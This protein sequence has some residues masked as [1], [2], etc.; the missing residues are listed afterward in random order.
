VE[1]GDRIPFV[2]TWFASHADPPRKINPEHALRDTEVF[3]G[4]W[5]KQ[6]QSELDL[7]PQHPQSLYQLAYIRLQQHQPSDATRLLEEVLKQQPANSDAHYQLGKALLEQGDVSA[8]TR[9][10]E[11]SIQL[12]PTDYAYFQ[13]SNAYTRNGRSDD[14]KRALGILQSR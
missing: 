10:L 14:A 4:D 1:K 8:A 12:H 9:E 3:W 5:A 2:L 6:F 7:N 11:A 13:L